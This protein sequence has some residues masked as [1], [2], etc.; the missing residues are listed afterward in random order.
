MA[1]KRVTKSIGVSIMIE[2][3]SIINSLAMLTHSHIL[4]ERHEKG[5]KNKFKTVVKWYDAKSKGKGEF[6]GQFKNGKSDR[7]LC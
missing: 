3:C 7:Y 4:V 2:S 6:R 5:Y 1:S